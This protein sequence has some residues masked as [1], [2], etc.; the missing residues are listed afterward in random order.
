MR[1]D[2]ILEAKT[3]LAD[4]VDKVVAGTIIKSPW[5]SGTD[6]MLKLLKS[7]KEGDTV[8][9]DDESKAEGQLIT[10]LGKYKS[11]VRATGI[12]IITLKPYKVD[13]RGKPIL[14]R[15]F[16]S[17]IIEGRNN[18]VFMPIRGVNPQ[19]INRIRKVDFK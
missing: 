11:G 4:W 15:G 9:I 2:K 3:S 6:N 18:L 19:K 8:E 16:Q 10:L 5:V 14:R 1:L 7:L 12:N 17:G 13:E